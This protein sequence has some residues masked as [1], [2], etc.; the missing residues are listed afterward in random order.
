MRL[1]ET[2]NLELA[3]RSFMLRPTLR[4]ALLLERAHGLDRLGEKLLDLNVTAIS[5]VIA[6]TAY[7]APHAEEIVALMLPGGLVTEAMR[8]APELLEL[9]NGLVGADPDAE[10]EEAADPGSHD[11]RPIAETLRELYRV[12][13]GKLGWS[14][15]ITLDATPLEILEAWRG[16][17]ELLA[18]IFGGSDDEAPAKRK[19][20]LDDKFGA[21]QASLASSAGATVA[22]A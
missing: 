21:L 18:A 6:A 3:G 13:T 4:A 15:A 14:P 7:G 16:R 20:S 1:A 9:V 19:G 10:A 5:D 12:G 22:A 17:R 11:H 8:L 2:I